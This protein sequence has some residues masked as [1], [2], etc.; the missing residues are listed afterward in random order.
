MYKIDHL[1]IHKMY[2]I[3]KLKKMAWFYKKN[4]YIL[5][6]NLNQLNLILIIDINYNLTGK[7]PKDMFCL[8]P[9]VTSHVSPQNKIT[10]RTSRG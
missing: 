3:P 1:V 7:S 4:I 2:S 8:D 9:L 6:N 10:M 5:C